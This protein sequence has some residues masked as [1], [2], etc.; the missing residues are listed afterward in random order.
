MTWTVIDARCGPPGHPTSALLSRVSAANG[1]VTARVAVPA[2][3]VTAAGLNGR[4]VVLVD[5]DLGA[6][7]LRAPTTGEIGLT[8]QSQG[9][10]LTQ[11]V[12]TSRGLADHPSFRPG[13]YPVSVEGGLVVI[14]LT[15]PA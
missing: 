1:A 4:A 11:S 7:A 9:R 14:D 8:L 2:A 15:R 10:Q 12:V 6:I 3:L 13:R 5:P